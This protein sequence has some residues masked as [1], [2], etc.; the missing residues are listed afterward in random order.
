MPSK[1]PCLSDSC[2][3]GCPLSGSLSYSQMP[4]KVPCLSDSCS[5]ECPLSY[6][7]MPS[8]VPCLS[9]SCSW[10]CPLSGPHSYS[11]MPSKVPGHQD[12]HSL[13]RPTS[14]FLSTASLAQWLRCLPQERKIM[15]SNPACT[16]I[17]WGSSHTSDFKIGT[18]VATLPGACGCRISA[19]SV[20]PGV[21]IL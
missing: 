14:S 17:F 6:I 5:W 11:Q 2:S 3:W 12:C 18:S 20:C 13:L 19:G 16:G 7:Q 4:S 21:S 1:V 8:K 10:L 15:G 9:D